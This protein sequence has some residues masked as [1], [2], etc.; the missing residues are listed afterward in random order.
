MPKGI[1]EGCHSG[2]RFD[3]EG[4]VIKNIGRPMFGIEEE[5]CKSVDERAQRAEKVD[6]VLNAEELTKE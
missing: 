3:W 4:W 1:D 5:D 2:S 6:A